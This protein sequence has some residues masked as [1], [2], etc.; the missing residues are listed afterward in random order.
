MFSDPADILIPRG[1][2]VPVIKENIHEESK[3]S[4]PH[5]HFH[6]IVMTTDKVETG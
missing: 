1:H 6:R 4:E 5:E 3:E 2:L